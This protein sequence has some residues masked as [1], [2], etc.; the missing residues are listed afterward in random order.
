MIIDKEYKGLI[1]VRILRMKKG[2]RKGM[3][4]KSINDLG[5]S[6]FARQFT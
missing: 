1:T 3:F 4:G 2:M 6:E 5:W